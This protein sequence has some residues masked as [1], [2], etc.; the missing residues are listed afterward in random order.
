MEGLLQI[1]D[2]VLWRGAWGDWPEREAVVMDI[3]YT[4]G[5][6]HG[7]P[8]EAIPWAVVKGR[9]CTVSLD[10]G[11]WAYGHQIRPKEGEQVA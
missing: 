3:Q 6:K 7:L 5:A 2:T 8:V 11:Y 1:G 9:D 10:N 4:K